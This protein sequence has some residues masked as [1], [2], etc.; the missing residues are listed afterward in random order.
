MER[1]FKAKAE[2][3]Q[4]GDRIE[5]NVG[6][7]SSSFTVTHGVQVMRLFPDAPGGDYGPDM[8][9]AVLLYLDPPVPIRRNPATAAV[10]SE[11]SVVVEAYTDVIIVIEQP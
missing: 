5:L 8:R 7:N 10:E 4:K 11:H 9:K 1:K 3:L 6:G 2:Q